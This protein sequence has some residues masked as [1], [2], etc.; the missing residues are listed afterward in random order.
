MIE[1]VSSERRRLALVLATRNEGKAHEIRALLPRLEVET[2]GAHP[3]VPP[4]AEDGETFA[5]NAIKKAEA[6]SKAL[7]L[8][9]L[10][11]DSGLAVD[12]LGGG[13]GVQ[14]ARYA[15][16]SDRDRI[17]KLLGALRDVPQGNR[18]A[19][20]V[21]AMAF[22]VPGLPTV[23]AEAQC[24]GRI[25]DSPRGR[26]GFGYDPV[27]L[28]GSGARTMAELTLEE[29][30]ALSHRGRALALILPAIERHFSL[31]QESPF[32]APSGPDHESGR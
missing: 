16:G 2:L 3:E 28:V 31:E 4:P 7:D 14:S 19:R 24:E 12:V 22:A 8:P 26:G 10:A 25:A 30:N 29:K 17:A 5:V 13:P 23:L 15:E 6:V 32:P 21:C 20:F 11:D 27:F 1:A 18:R 9:A